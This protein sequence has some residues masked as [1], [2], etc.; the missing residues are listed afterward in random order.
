MY[1][2][3][4][5][6]VLRGFGVASKNI[7]FQMPYLIWQFPELKDIHTATINVQ[8]EKP[9][10]ITKLERTTPPLPW[11]D[12]DVDNP[13]SGRWHIEQFSIVP[14]KFEFPVRTSNKEAW[15]FVSHGSAIFRNPHH[16]EVVAEKIDGL[17]PGN[18]CR[19]H[20]QKA[21]NITVG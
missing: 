14:I 13:N 12:V 9:L 5:A 17:A 8:L 1:L 4:D 16:Y 11:W 21:D 15:L 19:I 20:I 6:T 2:V 10:R 7:K 18:R 3:I